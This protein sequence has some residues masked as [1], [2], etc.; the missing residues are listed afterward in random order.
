MGPSKI[1]REKTLPLQHSNCWAAR[2]P[3]PLPLVRFSSDF[4]PAAAVILRNT[5][6]IEIHKLYNSTANDI[7]Q[8]GSSPVAFCS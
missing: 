3:L 4:K 5:A 8:N 6:E 2:L 7:E 1:R